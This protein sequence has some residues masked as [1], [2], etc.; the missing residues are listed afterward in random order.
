MGNESTPWQPR[1]CRET[2]RGGARFPSV[3]AGSQVQNQ[4][5]DTCIHF[6]C[7]FD[8]DL[9]N[10]PTTGENTR[11]SIMRSYDEEPVEFYL[12]PKINQ[13]RCSSWSPNPPSS[14]RLRRIKKST[15]CVY[16]HCSVHY[17]AY[18]LTGSSVVPMGKPLKVLRRTECSPKNLQYNSL[19]YF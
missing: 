4:T 1:N 13:F 10:E 3:T 14:P 17:S 15:N 19:I 12:S 9:T 16:I 6:L 18:T 2:R 7:E 11:S 8:D 5:C